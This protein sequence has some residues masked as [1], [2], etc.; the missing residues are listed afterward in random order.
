MFEKKNADNLKRIQVPNIKHVKLIS[1]EQII[2][3]AKCIPQATSCRHTTSSVN[4]H[5]IL[6][7]FSIKEYIFMI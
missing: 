7:I 1:F 3:F 2:T 5:R 4:S 6:H